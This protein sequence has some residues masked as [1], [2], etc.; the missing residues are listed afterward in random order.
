MDVYN[1]M[2]GVVDST[3]TNNMFSKVNPLDAVAAAKGL[4]HLQG[5][6]GGFPALKVKTINMKFRHCFDML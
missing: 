3:V 2:A 4:L 5:C 1:S 6:R